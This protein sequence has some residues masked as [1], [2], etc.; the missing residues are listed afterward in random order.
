MEW[1][2][3]GEA[4]PHIVT[5][6]AFPAFRPSF[7]IEAIA[8]LLP[9]QVSIHLPIPAEACQ[10]ATPT[11]G[12]AARPLV[13]G[14]LIRTWVCS[15]LECY[16]TVVKAYKTFWTLM[17]HKFLPIAAL[18]VLYFARGWPC[19]LIVGRSPRRQKSLA[20]SK[21]NHMAYT[22][23]HLSILDVTPLPRFLLN[24]E[25]KKHNFHELRLGCSHMLLPQ[26][27]AT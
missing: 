21:H 10:C 9:A 11:Y 15:D 2:C 8:P 13:N 12:V 18:K 19:E 4:V 1:C 26:F 23:S 27:L 17:I 3:A 20:L 16:C 5:L 24:W 14:G 25:Y 22:I 6:T 7:I